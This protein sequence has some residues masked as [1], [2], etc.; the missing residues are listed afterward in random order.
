MIPAEP[1][2]YSLEISQKTETNGTNESE[3]IGTIVVPTQQ[4]TRIG[5]PSLPFV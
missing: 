1:V 2:K 5:N 3:R 4:I